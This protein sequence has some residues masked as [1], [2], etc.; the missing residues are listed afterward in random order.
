VRERVRKWFGS[1]WL[2]PTRFRKKAFVDTIRGLYIPYWTFDSQV[3]CRWTADSGTYYY[4]N[5]SYTDGKGKRRTRRVRH[6]RWRSAS[7]ELQHF[8]DDEPVPGTRGL[9]ADLL[10]GIEPF[11]TADLVPYDTAYLS[12][13]VIEHY[14]VV[15]IDA[16]R[17]ARESIETQLRGMC[18]AR[19]P[20]DTYRNLVIAPEHSGETFKQILVPVWNLTYGYRRKT[21][22]LLING[23]T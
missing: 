14:Q 6:V 9:P 12:G 7:G 16:A 8:F 5:E 4:T 18:G 11:P 2:A 22:R 10:R 21:Y 23:Y 15:L 19:V 1:K 17:K 13:F 3:H 20:G